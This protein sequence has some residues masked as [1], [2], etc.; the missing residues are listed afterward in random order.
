MQPLLF[1][2]HTLD[3]TTPIP[4]MHFLMQNVPCKMTA[5]LRPATIYFT[6]KVMQTLHK[7]DHTLDMKCSRGHSQLINRRFF[8]LEGIVLHTFSHCFNGNMYL[9]LTLKEFCEEFLFIYCQHSR[10]LNIHNAP[11]HKPQKNKMPQTIELQRPSN[12][13]LNFRILTTLNQ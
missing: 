1:S 3:T 6:I 4:P 13:Y 5:R 9:I 8:D 2:D 11:V 7:C 10:L 12:C